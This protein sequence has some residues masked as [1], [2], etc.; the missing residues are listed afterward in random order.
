[1]TALVNGALRGPRLGPE[2]GFGFRGFGSDDRPAFRG[3]TA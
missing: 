2:H 3:T 1:M